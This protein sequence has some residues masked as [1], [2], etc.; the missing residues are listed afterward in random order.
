MKQD[1]ATSLAGMFNEWLDGA[2]KSAGRPVPVKAIPVEVVRARLARY[3]SADGIAVILEDAL[4]VEGGTIEG[5][6]FAA[7][8]IAT[9]VETGNYK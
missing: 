1:L 6:G 9:A 3:I 8:K 4:H 7:V 2:E 5:V